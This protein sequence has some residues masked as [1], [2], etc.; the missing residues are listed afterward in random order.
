MEYVSSDRKT[1]F[2]LETSRI[3]CG[4]IPKIPKSIEIARSRFSVA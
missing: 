2:Y 3:S 4:E 1:E